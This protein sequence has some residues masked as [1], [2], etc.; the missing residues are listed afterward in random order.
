KEVEAVIRDFPG[1]K[2]ATVQAFDEENGSGKFIA[3]YIVSDQSVD[4]EALNNFILEQKPPYMVP[5]VTMQID[6]IPLNQNFKVNKRALPKP[7]KKVEAVES[8][9]AP[10]N[11]LENEL[12][13]MIAAIAGNREFGI[14]TVLGNVGLTSI[15][16]IK[17]AVQANKRFGVSLDAKMLVKSG[18]LQS[19][20]NEILQR[21]MSGEEMGVNASA[22]GTP[23]AAPAGPVSIPLSYAQTGVY[24]DCLKNP[25]STVYNIPYSI[26]FPEG[27]EAR[28][29]AEALKMLVARHPLLTARFGDDGSDIVQTTRP[30]QPVDIPVKS[31]SEAEFDA[32]KHAF[33][34]PFDLAAGPL[35]RFELVQAEKKLYLLC[36]VHH[37]VFDGSS[38]DLFLQQLCSLMNGETLEEEVLDYAGYVKAEKAAE[39][40]PDYQ[41][42]QE[43]FKSR[44]TGYEA[45]TEV[46]SDLAEPTR[47]AIDSVWAELDLPTI[48]TFARA[49]NITPAHLILAATYY[50]LS[51]FAGSDDL[52][53]A[54]I[55]SGRS[56]LRIRNTV[57]MFVNTLAISA[58]IGKQRI[59]EFLQ[60]V[61]ADFDETLRH[62]NYPFARIAA[63]YGLSAEIFFVYQL[64]VI[65]QYRCK[66][67]PL[68]LENLELKV[69]KCPI[70]FYIKEVKGVPGVYLEYDNG[71]YSTRL[72]QALADAIPATAR[73]MT[74]R[75]DEA[76]TSLGS[77]IPE[78]AP[79]RNRPA[80]EEGKK[81]YAQN[82]DCGDCYSPLL[83]DLDGTAATKVT[84]T[85]TMQMD[86]ARVD[87]YCRENGLSQD[88]FFTAVY[89]YLL[90][91]FN[92]EQQALFS[93]SDAD[94]ADLPVKS[95]PVYA[96]FSDETSV[97][98][99]LKACREQ[100][101]GCREHEAYSYSDA[102]SDLG[103][104]VATMFGW[105]GDLSA[106]DG[107]KSMS[108]NASEVPL[109]V[110][111]CLRDGRGCI[112]AEYSAE[113]HSAKLVSQFLESYEAVA[114]GFLSKEFL[115]EIDLSTV[116]QRDLLDRFNETDIPYD[117]TQTI[118]SLFRRQAKATP[119]ET[120]VVFKDKTYTYAEVDD[121]SDRIAAT[122]T[123]KGLGA[124][125]VVS[126]LIPRCEWMVIASLGV[127]KAGCAYQPL[128]PSYPKE[129]LNFMMQDANAKVLIADEALRPI[130]E[131]FK[132][133]VLLTK[134]LAFL[135][136]AGPIPE[137]PKP[138]SLFILLYT[139]GST[140]VPKGCQL[141]HSNLVCF[142]HWYQRYF[143]LKP[144]NKVAAYASYGFDACMMDIYCGITCGVPVYIIPEEMRLDLVALNDYFEKEAITHAFMTT[145]VA[146]QFATS[147]EN[148][149]LLHL[150]TG[151][152]KL[153]SFAPPKG[154][155]FHNGYGPTE[156]TIFTTIYRV[157]EKRKDI[158]IGKPLD[159]L[160]LF[161]VD[162]DLNRLPLGAAGELLVSGPQ[163]SRG[164]LNLPEKTADTYITW[165][166][167][168]CY[169]T[170]DIVRYLKD[171]NVQFVGRRDGQVKIR[172]FRI[173]L[174]E[175]EAVIREYPGIKDA[176]VQAFD[177]PNGGKFI[178]AYVVCEQP[179]DIQALNAFI[180]ER[181]P[182]YMVPAATMQLEEIPL[183][184]NQKVNRRA[185]P[186]PQIQA[187]SRDYVAPAN[188]LE[189]LFCDIF[190]GILSMDKVGATDNFF[191]L[192]GTSLMVT[193]VVIE[194]DKAGKHVAYGDVFSHPSPRL[195]AQ[196][197][198]GDA[199]AGEQTDTEVE[200]FDYS[201]I[202][203]LLQHNNVETFLKGERQEV[204]AEVVEEMK[205]AA[206]KEDFRKAARLR[207]TVAALKEMTKAHF[208]R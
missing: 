178:A 44:L 188:E 120:A 198:S 95:F 145:Q 28:A 148:R 8:V 93:G 9:S 194:A 42:A 84:Q 179:L 175:V 85:R 122:L 97:L 51:R 76:L 87:A 129:R 103:L 154:Y 61:S 106:Q 99:F 65:S 109:S 48:N 59:R 71:R 152:E 3:A 172:G 43:W 15:S 80:F 27:T 135:P 138:G 100:M 162:K 197:V 29:V 78:T 133:D 167:K 49:N 68:E 180:R 158:P 57:G 86:M 181:K 164:Y 127:S 163:V 21:M 66:G 137:G 187:E 88:S 114:E 111:G 142:C 139:S 81:W 121:I 98:D 199:L 26:A 146:Y 117:D 110:K 54:T 134:D 189:K 12:F 151:G 38:F 53:I 203:A 130:V 166:G 7:E 141:M 22:A 147:M 131:D 67:T 185:L 17:L 52:C 118:V 128:D 200:E 56:D 144:G 89:A 94:S 153:A 149:S 83:P 1:I 33:V 159:N 101:N 39:G 107:G 169:R 20:E 74:E 113:V 25:S 160:Q 201:G 186:A 157:D 16:A 192:G 14:T 31:M 168:R 190:A 92:N 47:G 204:I 96:R 41:A 30:D 45:A 143:D 140:G 119:R 19:I 58:H 5:A 24:F 13:E 72:M 195:L 170:G 191:E 91:K 112:E 165:E 196:F 75:P 205:E 108:A 6:A 69:P 32:Y 77:L 40:G 102:V 126:I 174:K 193:K 36:D 62:E 11:V 202:D 34:R 171:G 173:E 18:T 4:V 46:P 136:M 23:T 123:A 35:Y 206:A 63:D 177:Y 182:P 10:M 79:L 2:D 184:Q 70:M 116:S 132:G 150:S 37:L 105:H 104:Q 207:D 64:G 125:D 155:R 90:A 176:T 73:R 156:A 55:S 82:F 60:E 124:E 183:N 208:V 50:A 115:R 161:I